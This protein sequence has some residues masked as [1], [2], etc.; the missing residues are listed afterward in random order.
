MIYIGCSY[1]TQV[2][3]SLN[4]CTFLAVVSSSTLLLIWETYSVEGLAVAT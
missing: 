3:Y 4:R 2:N 1:F